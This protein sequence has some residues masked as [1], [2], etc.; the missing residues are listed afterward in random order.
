[1]LQRQRMRQLLSTSVLFQVC[2]QSA[3]QAE[4]EVAL[5]GN[6]NLLTACVPAL[7]AF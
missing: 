3:V 2:L 1:M 7:A 5:P 6:V 4:G